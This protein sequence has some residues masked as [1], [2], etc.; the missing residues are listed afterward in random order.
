VRAYSDAYT[1]YYNDGINQIRVVASYADD[2]VP[3][4]DQLLAL[5]PQEDLEKLAVAFASYYVH[6]W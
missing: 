3:G 6:E 5:A 4:I 1:I 2:A